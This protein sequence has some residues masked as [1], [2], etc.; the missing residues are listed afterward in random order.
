MTWVELRRVLREFKLN[1]D[2]DHQA[3]LQELYQY[4]E[5]ELVLVFYSQQILPLYINLRSGW[6]GLFIS[7]KKLPKQTNPSNW[8]LYAR[9]HLVG[10]KLLQVELAPNSRTIFFDFERHQLVAELFHSKA[11][12]L[13]LN[14]EN[15]IERAFNRHAELLE[16][17]YEPAEAETN[18]QQQKELMHLA[19]SE[20]EP[21]ISRLLEKT[22]QERFIT[23]KERTRRKQLGQKFKQQ[24]RKISALENE[25]EE[26]K[27]AEIFLRYGETLKNNLY[28]FKDRLLTPPQIQL[29]I[30]DETLNIPIPK[31]M[32]AQKA[33]LLYFDRHKKMLRKRQ[34]VERR[35]VIE[36]ASLEKMRHESSLPTSENVV[37]PIYNQS[38]KDS[39]FKPIKGVMQQLSPDGYRVLVGKSAE[40]NETLLKLAKSNDLWLHVR[41]FAGS[42]CLIVRQGKKEIPENVIAWTAKLALKFSKAKN[43]GQGDIEVAL[44]GD[45]KKFKHAKPGQVLVT[46]SRTIH[47]KLES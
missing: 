5:D 44:R 47:V 27:Q 7:Q 4:S 18:A 46:R 2:D 40:G 9:K 45:I 28:Q 22:Y 43:Q 38:H 23:E 11:N 42:H 31:S 1:L 12:L 13:L 37:S 6:T 3:R 14:Q 32:P 8:V 16:Q 17:K 35:L 10:Q 36:R 19:T 24:N 25:L 29:I 26:A 21:S 33:M 34:E 30:D 39:E 15:K 41:N 20:N